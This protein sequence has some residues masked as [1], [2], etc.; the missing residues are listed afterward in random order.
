MSP[1]KTHLLYSWTTED[2]PACQRVRAERGITAGEFRVVFRALFPF[3]LYPDAER[4]KWIEGIGKLI[5]GET[6]CRRPA[7]QQ[8]LEF[9]RAGRRRK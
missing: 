3:G 4:I 8:A 9:V 7:V 1:S 6:T 5:D 2:D